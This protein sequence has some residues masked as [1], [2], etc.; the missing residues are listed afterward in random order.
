MSAIG[1]S[2]GEHAAPGGST[3]STGVEWPGEECDAVSCP[4]SRPG[5]GLPLPEPRLPVETLHKNHLEIIVALRC[6]LTLTLLV[7]PRVFLSLKESLSSACELLW[8]I[9]G[10]VGAAIAYFEIV[11]V[12]TFSL[13]LWLE[14]SVAFHSEAHSQ[15]DVCR[16][17]QSRVEDRRIQGVGDSYNILNRW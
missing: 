5:P 7:S 17:V 6:G 15:E 8:V 14:C 9:G 1:S 2:G 10:G 12:S 16:V 3:F 13:C 11:A 4:R